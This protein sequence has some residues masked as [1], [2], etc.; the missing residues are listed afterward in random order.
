[1]NLIKSVFLGLE[2]DTFEWFTK[3]LINSLI[4]CLQIL[5]IWLSKYISWYNSTFYAIFP[6]KFRVHDAKDLVLKK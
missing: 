2:F 6:A 1:M 3:L 4:S 5:K